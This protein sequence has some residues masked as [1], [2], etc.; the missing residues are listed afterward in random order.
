MYEDDLE[1]EAN[2]IN[3]RPCQSTNMMR[4]SNVMDMFGKE[5]GPETL[6][7]TEYLEF[8]NIGVYIE[9]VVKLVLQNDDD[10]PRNH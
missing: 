5:S 10:H 1:V 6:S 4:V 9:D 7:A 8:Y 3:G 2:Q